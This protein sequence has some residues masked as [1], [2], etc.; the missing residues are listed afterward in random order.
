MLVSLVLLDS[1][2]LPQSSTHEK[3]A[4]MSIHEEIKRRREALGW[5]QTRLAQEVSVLE[6]RGDKP[7]SWQTVQQWESRTAP[8][9]KRVDHVATALGCTVAD[10][11]GFVTT[12]Y[13]EV[14]EKAL[15][16]HAPPAPP[17]D[18]SDRHE[19][20]DTDWGLLQDVH[21]VMT[22]DELTAL[23]TRA[24]RLRRIAQEQ[25]ETVAAAAPRP[26]SIGGGSPDWKQVQSPLRRRHDDDQEKLG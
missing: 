1:L 15:A 20:S 19:V 5:S 14:V 8:S 26:P 23:R 24:E 21:L 18:F 2:A 3:L 25:L 12:N 16:A 6:G 9:R 10:L 17:R 4:A 13:D 7:L 22:D 11:L